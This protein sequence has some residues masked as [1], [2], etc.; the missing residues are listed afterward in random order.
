MK[1]YPMAKVKYSIILPV[2]NGG[3]YIKECVNSILSQTFD[4]FELIVLIHDTTD[5]TVNWLKSLNKKKI[6]IHYE[7]GVNGIIG[8]WQRALSVPKGE[9][10]TIIGYDDLLDKDYL[11]TIDSFVKAYPDAS[12]YQTHFNYINSTGGH[13]KKC[14][15]MPLKENAVDFLKSFLANSV[16]IMATGF[17]M[18]SKDYDA[19]GGI[20]AYPNLLF[21][22][23]EL[24]L[25]LTQ[26]G[27]KVTAPNTTFSFRIHQ[28]V[29]TTSSD[30]KLQQAF[31]RVIL[32]LELL[33]I[34]DE[35]MA[36]V[37]EDNA[38]PFIHYYCKS[39]SHRLIRTNKKS[40][41]GVSVATVIKKCKQ[42]A[43]ILVPGNN[44]NPV[45]DYKVKFAKY[46]DSN[47]LLSKMFLMLRKIY[48]K[49][50]YK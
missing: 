3:D 21:A 16:D 9:F 28:S 31:E 24:W 47:L 1:L 26:I 32:F 45:T 29:T 44:Y 6:T 19:L 7:D 8:N 48:K 10:M 5:D 22:D 15:P 14:K 42:Y 50:I 38:I 18:R 49:P 43:D 35:Q 41:P 46:I 37:I 36:K 33:K 2:K 11:Q 27:Y 30:E 40:R 17:M 39:L 25:R 34:E 23:M 13:I 4:D 20:P 12:L